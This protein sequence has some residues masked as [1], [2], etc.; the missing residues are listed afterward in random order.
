MQF[1]HNLKFY[2]EHSRNRKFAHRHF[3]KTLIP[4]TL[5]IRVRIDLSYTQTLL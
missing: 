2:Y 1:L 3:Y 4:S 5:G